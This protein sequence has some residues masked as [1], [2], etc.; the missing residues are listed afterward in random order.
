M[1]NKETIESAVKWW[2]ERIDTIIQPD[3]YKQENKIEA[4]FKWNQLVW[5]EI[6]MFI[7][8]GKIEPGE[9]NWLCKRRGF[10]KVQKK[11]LRDAL[12]HVG[13]LTTVAKTGKR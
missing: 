5:Q 2:N 8:L 10:N 13:L 11:F 1:I 12:W 3:I 9:L 6:N 4:I 7:Q